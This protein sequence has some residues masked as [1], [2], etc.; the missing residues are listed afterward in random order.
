MPRRIDYLTR[1]LFISLI[2]G[3]A[4]FLTN[5][6]V[7]AAV[8]AGDTIPKIETFSVEGV[9][10]S[11]LPPENKLMLIQFWNPDS[12]GSANILKDTI[13]LYK[14]FHGK[15]FN[16]ISACTKGTEDSI[17]ALSEQWQI[18]W[19]QVL[20]DEVDD[21]DLTALSKSAETPFNI[22]IDSKGTILAI[23]LKG[24]EGHATVAERLGVSLGDV[25]K[26]AI[27]TPVQEPVRGGIST[28]AFAV[29]RGMPGAGKFLGTPEERQEAEACKKNLRRIGLAITQY[30]MDHDGEVPNW[31]SDLYPKY[32]DD[33]QVFLCP[34]NPEE[35]VWG[36]I[37][38]PNLDT[39]YLYEF[40]PVDDGS[41]RIYKDWKTGQLSEY[42]D[43]VVMARCLNHGPK[44][45]GLTYGG[46]IVFTM[47]VWEAEMTR[48][49]TLEDH[50]CQVRKRLQELA[51]ALDRYK[52]D[53]GDVPGELENL[54]PDYVKDKALFTDPVTKNP[55]S[56]QF[57]ASQQGTGGVMKDW[58]KE[59][60]KQFGDYVPIVRARNVYDD[61][62]IVI[63][64]SYGG[65]I[66]QSQS[67]W[68]NDL[69]ETAT[70]TP[71]GETETTATVETKTAAADEPEET[72]DPNDPYLK[73]T[74][75][76]KV[77]SKD[78]RISKII[79]LIG[80]QTGLTFV[81]QDG[82]DPPVSFQ[83]DNPTLK[84]FFDE[85]L[86]PAGLVPSKR[87]DGSFYIKYDPKVKEK[88]Q[89]KAEKRDS[90]NVLVQSQIFRTDMDLSM[91]S[92]ALEAFFIDNNAYPVLQKDGKTIEN[93]AWVVDSK[94]ITLIDP[95]AYVSRFPTDPFDKENKVYRYKSDGKTWWI[96][97]SNGPD[98]EISLDLDKYD[99]S[100]G[101]GKEQLKEF[102]YNASKG[103]KSQGDIF[104]TGP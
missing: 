34:N 85:A 19:P 32:I 80:K 104:K 72:L 75:Q 43:K 23:D 7:N 90:G 24:D 11:F 101:F 63:N 61:P 81:L 44:Y 12:S 95:V 38:D 47:L 42:G 69:S 70:T 94:T 73:K 27:P 30:R 102:T 8:N 52:K 91:L 92:N 58:K 56:Y 26:P 71:D 87:P 64:L 88:A 2:A 66:W 59:Q 50:D 54:Y 55:F 4:A 65:E 98:G 9:P 82:I 103:V 99:P 10:V 14:R 36:N 57:S 67:V 35:A 84:E 48:G 20:I 46:E 100:K 1:F 16:V 5:E 68:E 49:H 6:Q 25:P 77:E 79:D 76:G 28:Q 96:L 60:L 89:A 86:L 74:I 62:N 93:A 40:A 13:V 29:A 31:L 78:I 53:K 45:P 22:L 15:G 33:K 37:D 41:G 97:A 51:V 3:Y 83:L 21:D 18:P 39:S 17:L